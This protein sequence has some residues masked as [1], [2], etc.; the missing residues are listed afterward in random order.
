MDRRRMALIS[1]GSA[2]PPVSGPTEAG[3]A[4][5]YLLV[6]GRPKPTEAGDQPAPPLANTR[7]IFHSAPTFQII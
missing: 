1:V 7:S 4:A 5:F 3:T 2:E 6:D